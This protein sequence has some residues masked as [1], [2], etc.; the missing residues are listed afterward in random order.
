MNIAST[1]IQVL[2]YN[3]QIL[4]LFWKTFKPRN[5]WFVVIILSEELNSC[6]P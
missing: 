4:E 6:D 3:Q 2:S 5:S 1:I